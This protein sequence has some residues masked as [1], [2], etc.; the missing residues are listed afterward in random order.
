MH[1]PA[2]IASVLLQLRFVWFSLGP[3][4][5]AWAICLAYSVWRGFGLVPMAFLCSF[6]FQSGPS[7]LSLSSS[8]S[9]SCEVGFS[10]QHLGFSSPFC[11]FRCPLFLSFGAPWLR[12][13]AGPVL[14]SFSNTTAHVQLVCGAWQFKHH[15]FPGPNRSRSSSGRPSNLNGRIC[16]CRPYKVGHEMA[17]HCR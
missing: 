2:P 15:V 4:G 8:G 12:P 17:N 5:L 11:A 13:V 9:P 14:M 1:S 10:Q 6:R 3:F 7:G 16:R